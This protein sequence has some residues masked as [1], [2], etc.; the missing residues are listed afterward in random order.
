[1][2]DPPAKG[3]I[4]LLYPGRLPGLVSIQGV[5]VL[6]FGQTPSRAFGEARQCLQVPKPLQRRP[7]KQHRPL[8]KLLAYVC[9]WDSPIWG[10]HNGPKAIGHASGK[11]YYNVAASP[12]EERRFTKGLTI[13]NYPSL[14][15]ALA[16]CG[17]EGPK[18]KARERLRF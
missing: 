16:S 7:N 1:M 9:I 13:P 11:P 2:L 18:R 14:P 15:P 5:D 17:P 12:P 8:S 6:G 4:A 10:N 3:I